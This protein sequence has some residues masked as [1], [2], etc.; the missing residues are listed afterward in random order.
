MKHRCRQSLRPLSEFAESPTTLGWRPAPDAV[1]LDKRHGRITHMVVLE[2]G[3]PAYDFPLFT[4]FDGAAVL[5]IDEHGRVLLV[6]LE[7]PALLKRRRRCH[8]PGL[9]PP[10]DYG[11]IVWEAPRGFGRANERPRRTAARECRE[12]TGVRPAELIGVGEVTTNST[13]RGNCIRL[14]LATVR[15]P[16]GDLRPDP[17]E[18]IVDRRFF[19]G[20]EIA[21]MLEA[22]EIVCG[23]TKSLLL[24][25]CVRGCIQL[26]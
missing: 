1:L 16:M 13:F 18:R 12:E 25:A 17:H 2:D 9:N 22:G 3:Q 11:R 24:H 8:F 23:I 4:E 21:S 14:F 7:R 10:E 6:L 20:G 15:G 19:S 5:P 26:T